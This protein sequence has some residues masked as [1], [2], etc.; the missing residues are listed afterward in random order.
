M[1]ARPHI[2]HRHKD[3]QEE[4]TYISID[5]KMSKNDGYE[6]LRKIRKEW[7]IYLGME[8]VHY[9]HSIA[10]KINSVLFLSFVIYKVQ[11]V[12][13]LIPEMYVYVITRVN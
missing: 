12:R 10:S 4:G 6:L 13:V 8:T 1:V 11:N 3:T 2:N 5:V 7:Q 9:E